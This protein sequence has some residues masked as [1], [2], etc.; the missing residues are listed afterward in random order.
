MCDVLN[1]GLSKCHHYLD[2]MVIHHR[3]PSAYVKHLASFF[4]FFTTEMYPIQNPFEATRIAFLL[5]FLSTLLETGV[6]YV[7]T[8]EFSQLQYHFWFFQIGRPVEMALVDFDCTQIPP[9]VGLAARRNR[10]TRC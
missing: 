8:S 3:T 6:E 4:G 10:S 7:V 5:H 2:D 9:R 1:D